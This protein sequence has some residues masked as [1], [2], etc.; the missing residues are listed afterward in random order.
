MALDG[1]IKVVDVPMPVLRHGTL[2]VAN[3][4]SLISVGTERS[5][6]ELGEKSLLQ[7][8]RARPDLVRKVVERARTEGLKSTLDV[9]RDRLASLTPIGYSAAGLVLEVGQGVEGFAPGDR[10]ACGGEGANHAEV[11]AVPKNL[12]A[13][14][15]D[16]VPFE[17]AAYA[18]IGAI[19]L[20]GVRQ[21]DVEIGEWIGVIGLGL[22]GQLAARIA[23]AAGCRVVGIDLDASAVELAR[24]AATV[25]F[26]RDD[27]GLASGVRSLTGGLGLDAVLLCASSATSDP[28]ALAVELARDRGRVVI[29]GDT[30]IDVDRA[31]M[32]EKELEL[33]MSRSYGPGRYDLEYEERGRDLPAGYVR[34]T[35]QRNMQ[36]FLDLVAA[37]TVEPSGLT[38]HR[39]PIDDAPEAYRVITEPRDGE[40]AFG[41]VLTYESE[42]TPEPRPRVARATAASAGVALI[43]PGAFARATL[44]PALQAEGA[45]LVA[46]A[47][48]RGL[49]AADVATRFGFER[50][51]G[52]LDEILAG[53]D[54]AAVVISTRHATHASFVAAALDAEKAVFVEKPLALTPEQLEEV[55]RALTPD[56][57]LMVGFN[58]RFVPLVE[59]LRSEIG[60]SDDLVLSVRVNAGPLPDDHWLHDPEDGGGRLVGEGCHFVD[61]L[62]D[63]AASPVIV[64][65]AVAVPQPGRPIECSDSFTAHLRFENAVASLVYSGGG[66]PKL[67][68]ERLEVFGGGLAAVLDDLRVLGVT[69]DGKRRE[70]KSS[71]DKGH[72]AS[73]ARF[74]AAVR[75]TVEAPPVA[76][77]LTSTRITLG[78]VESLRSGRPVDMSSG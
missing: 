41:V 4:C 64:A 53:D 70:W 14:I 68:K 31:P 75:G 25:A 57:I 26:R 34:W 67:P 69:R 33:R 35:E 39:F 27:T 23:R 28:L 24:T 65:H 45:R 1:E 22:V 37:G 54:V 11:L 17:D 44:L 30:R 20:H 59:R 77:Y 55:E 15:P 50:T 72:R 51:A 8:A 29:V 49:T 47:S 6:V 32:Y 5:K 38:T 19:A 73:I 62:S 9:T 78:L 10:V 63:V 16:G 56:S 66:D 40:R 61:L 58:R 71:H 21:A 76:S 13:G 36:A 7:K 2:L 52:S 46:V 18:T 42:V 60:Q 48:S 3:C 12:V 74:L 43:G